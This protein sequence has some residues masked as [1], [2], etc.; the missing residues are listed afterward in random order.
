MCFIHPPGSIGTPKFAT[1]P[2]IQEGRVVLDPA[3]NGD[4]IHH[5]SAFGRHLFQIAAA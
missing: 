4:M 5:N 2:L 3:P 1:Q